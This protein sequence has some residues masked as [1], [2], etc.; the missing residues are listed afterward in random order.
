MLRKYIYEVVL[1]FRRSFVNH[2]PA[3]LFFLCHVIQRKEKG[4]TLSEMA[5]S[6]PFSL[7]Y[8]MGVRRAKERLTWQKRKSFFF[9]FFFLNEMR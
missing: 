3:Q 9:F 5:T 7:L 4:E 1:P 2:L 8:L 6:S